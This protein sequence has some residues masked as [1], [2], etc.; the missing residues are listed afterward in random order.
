M[1]PN[2]KDILNFVALETNYYVNRHLFSCTTVTPLIGSTN[3][4]VS[5]LLILF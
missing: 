1:S 5:N 4:I 3:L 2:I